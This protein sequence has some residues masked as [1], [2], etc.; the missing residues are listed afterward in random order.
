MK[1]LWLHWRLRLLK[2]LKEDSFGLV[3]HA[4]HKSKTM[5]LDKVLATT[6]LICGSLNVDESNEAIYKTYEPVKPSISV[7][8][9]GKPKVVNPVVDTPHVNQSWRDR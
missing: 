2:E 7:D 4:M 3:L 6:L 8:V 1:K 9:I 5:E